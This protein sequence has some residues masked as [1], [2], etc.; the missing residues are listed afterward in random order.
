MKRYEVEY[1]LTQK[2]VFSAA[3]PEEAREKAEALVANAIVIINSEIVAGSL[4]SEVLGVREKEDT[5]LSLLLDK[6]R[7]SKKFRAK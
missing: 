1:T 2:I 3:N 6:I 7:T 5:A 4:H